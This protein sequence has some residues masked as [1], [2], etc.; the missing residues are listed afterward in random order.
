[1]IHRRAWLI[2]TATALMATFTSA[3]TIAQD[4]A[5]KGEAPPA[6][7]AKAAGT[8]DEDN[9]L[10]V[11]PRSPESLMDAVVLMTDLARP[12]LA[13][14]Y[15]K[16]LL[17]AKLDEATLL[18]LRDRHGPATFLRLSNDKRL[19]PESITLLEQ[20]NAAFR[21][22]A[23]DPARVDKLIADLSKSSAQREVAI[24]QL[25]N[26]GTFAAARLV[27]V[28]NSSKQ[29]EQRKILLYTLTRLNKEVVPVLLGAVEAPNAELR[30]TVIEALGW[31]DDRSAVTWL[32]HP[33]FEPSQPAG[34]TL[35][36][37]QALARLL[38]GTV[39]R[40]P[41][42]RSF[43]ASAELAKSARQ[44]L[45]GEAPWSLNDEG[46]VELWDWDEATSTVT[47]SAVPPETAAIRVGT[48]IA[49]QAFE[50]SPQRTDLNALYWT[51]LMAQKLHV[52]GRE[53]AIQT[54]PG[55]TF[56]LGLQLG[57]EVMQQAL[58]EA[59]QLEQ[60]VAA[61]AALQVLA[62]TGSAHQLKAVS[63]HVAPVVGALNHPDPR[64]QFSAAST[65]LTWNPTTS[66]RG[67]SRVVEVL[68]RNL[69]DAGTSRG[70]AID[71]N[72]QRATTM[73]A[74]LREMGFEPDMA[75]TGQDGFKL[76]TERGDVGLFLIEANVARWELSQTLANLRADAR[77]AYIP[78]IVYGD[79]SLRDRVER[80]AASY[81]RVRFATKVSVASEMTRQVAPYLKRWRT[82]S[83]TQPQREAT[84]KAALD[85]FV[86]L[87]DRNASSLFDLTRAE[88]ALMA[89]TNDEALAEAAVFVLGAISTPPAQ[90]KLF[91]IATTAS[92]PDAVRERALSQLTAHFQ[93]HGMLLTSQQ[94]DELRKSAREATAPELQSA[95]A[96]A[97]GALH[98][99]LRTA[100]ELLK[101]VPARRAKE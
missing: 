81:S 91:E 57:P 93:R 94:A 14:L 82:E 53:V 39:N 75:T 97:L 68:T 45:R 78:I 86:Q 62:Q 73:S 13:H 34:V 26:G 72:E 5:A 50:L 60:P 66:F 18:K 1:M 92:R 69:A 25:R 96:A 30:A 12:N 3:F 54:D 36:A 10:L 35:A 83:M 71:A 38:F 76:A 55:S 7:P 47:M 41:D 51:A 2:L 70:V 87:A 100:S 31:L 21:K 52:A 90:T 63:G 28:L 98:P 42:V 23:T 19:Q 101:A 77:T 37:R 59:L 4:N 44:H 24:L 46:L 99:D 58:T 49:R 84:R 56:H 29:D 79:D 64:V 61:V 74:A 67:A 43:G 17:E 15:L 88:N 85:W 11:E 8:V 16:K 40:T 32:W 6:A 9:P 20:V 22:G 65:I 89:A 80:T 27:S 48:Q 33:A 95:F